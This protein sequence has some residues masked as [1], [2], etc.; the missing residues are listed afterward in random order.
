MH[1]INVLNVAH[2]QHTHV[3]IH[4]CAHL[5]LQKPHITNGSPAAHKLQHVSAEG[6][7]AGVPKCVYKNL[8]IPARKA[9]RE[10]FWLSD[11]A[12]P[13]AQG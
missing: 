9:H 3:H 1:E 10:A 8:V 11:K 13:K 6:L 5:W 12:S 7:A 2:T 4:A